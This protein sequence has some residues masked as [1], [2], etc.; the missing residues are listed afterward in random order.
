MGALR[1]LWLQHGPADGGVVGVRWACLPLQSGDCG[2]RVR[3]GGGG[4][5]DGELG[6]PVGAVAVHDEL[7]SRRVLQCVLR[8][9]MAETI[10][11]RPDP[12]A[13]RA[14]AVLTSDGTPV[15]AVVRAALIESAT[16]RV[17]E[18]IRAEAEA[19][20]A[21]PEDRAEIARVLQDM[22]SLRAW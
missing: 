19:V 17:R 16:A 5:V 1:S 12:A 13:Q 11:F 21:D 14:I 8:F 18:Q 9:I 3:F 2:Q 6:V 10:T 4:V 7:P 15:S 22:E 20:A